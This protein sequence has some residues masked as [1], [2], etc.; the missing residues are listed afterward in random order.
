[1]LST[2]KSYIKAIKFISNPPLNID[3]YINHNP[4]VPKI[5]LF[6]LKHYF[7]NG[8]Y[9]NR[10]IELA[11]DA[12]KIAVTGADVKFKNYGYVQS[13][14][15]SEFYEKKMT[16]DEAAISSSQ[17]IAFYLPQYHRIKENDEWWG[18]GFTEWTNVTKSLPQFSGHV[19]P[20][21]PGEFGFYDLLN[22][23]IL[24]E[25]IALAKEYMING[26]C[27]H[28]Y[29]FNGR[30]LLEKPVDIFLEDKKKYD[31]PF[32][33]C[34][35]NENWTRRWDG[36]ENDVLLG[37]THTKE[38]DEKFIYD[39]IKLFKDERY[40]KIQ[41]KPMLIVYRASLLPDALKT[42]SLWRK[43]CVKEG[44]GGIHLVAAQTF[45]ISDPRKYGFDAAVEFPPHGLNVPDISPHIPTLNPEFSGKIY[46]Y[47]DVVKASKY[48]K[49]TPYKVYK[50]VFPGW[51]NS[52]RKGV[53]S[54]IFAYSSPCFFEGWVKNT[55]KYTEN[56]LE[57]DKLFF[58]NAWNEW[59]E[60]AHLEPCRHYGYA[61]LNAL[62][63]GRLK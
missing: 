58:V 39:M 14:Y 5:K 62:Y 48:P 40:I 28:Y 2:I 26:F 17:C 22:P 21:L 51:D 54:H 27:F 11:E 44:I 36:Q 33:V 7:H 13:S 60:G 63:R 43:I 25:Q 1:M 34:W 16:V 30:R 12:K 37:Q 56:R 10:N 59:A 45:G 19:Q 3:K 38:S 31:F 55:V 47:E 18:K 50:T 49:L 32:C 4:D 23:S 8:R 9:E 29:W 41:G 20:K 24:E 42:T 46:G 35:A 15:S 61:S 53:H 57:G 52:A 6:A